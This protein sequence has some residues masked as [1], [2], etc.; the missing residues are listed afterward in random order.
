MAEL[1]KTL[2]FPVILIITINSIMG[3]G[4]FFLPALGAKLAGP[5]SLISWLIMAILAMGVS[6]IFAELVGMYP[7][8]GGVYEYTKQAFGP[9]VSFLVGWLTMIAG[10]VTIAMLVVGAVQYLSP[11]LPSLIKI[12]ISI[13]FILAF[14][15]MAFRGMQTSAVM[16]VAFGIVTLL[17]VLGLTIPGLLHFNV[18]NFTPFATHPISVM[19]LTVFFIAETFFGW[20]TATFL[21]EETKDAKHVMPKAMWLG[22]LIIAIIVLTFVLSSLGSIHWTEFGLSETPLADLATLHY[23]GGATIIFSLLVYLSIIGSVAGWIVSAPRLL[24]SLAQDKLFIPHLADIHPRFKTPHKSILFQTIL[25]SILV[26]IGAGSY[27]TLLHL[28]LPIVLILYTTVIISFLLLRYKKPDQERPFKIWAG[29]TLGFVL[30][31]VLISL[32]VTWVIL[33]SGALHTLELAGGF[34][35]LG[36]PIFFLLMF[37]YNPDAIILFMESFAHLHLL[38]EGINIPKKVRKEIVY[39]LPDLKGKKVLDFGSGVGTM[40]KH[41]MKHVGEDGH[42]IAI[43]M[44]KKNLNIL[45]KRLKKRK[46]TNFTILHDPHQISRVHPDV[47][48][49]DIVVSVGML[50]YIQDMKKVLK[51]LHRLLP[52]NGGICFVEY[53]DFFWFLPNAGWLKDEQKLLELFQET[54]FKVELVKTNGLFWKYLFIYGKKT[55]HMERVFI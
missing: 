53:I 46:H 27:E 36:V 41:L 28:L 16:L 37:Y 39:S 14:N 38:F 51:E 21:A 42:I 7:F 10:N 2:S 18:N 23:G 30:I 1:E 8:A 12:I 35:V 50:S 34:L 45:E 48:F 49:I 19:L 44:S 3:T 22:T 9:L 47:P 33:D 17:S 32:I 26:I 15:F 11:V 6:L 29:K 4:I 40:S 5:M 25:T 31:I 55:R 20:E 24:M 54:G 52:E 13:G 43:D